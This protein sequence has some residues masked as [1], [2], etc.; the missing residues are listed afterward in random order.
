[1]NKKLL[2]AAIAGTL[3]APVAIADVAVSG[4]I[5]VALVGD[6]DG[7]NTEWNI[8][9]SGSRL[10]FKAN[11]DLG[12]G[13]SG[14]VN[15][16]FGV[17]AGNGSIG[18]GSRNRLTVVGVKG[19][20]GNL[21]MGS[22]WSTQWQMVGNFIDKSN[23][24]GGQ[25]YQGQYRM[26]NSVRFRTELGALDLGVDAQMPSGGDDIDR[27]TV[28]LGGD[29][30]AVKWGVAWQNNGDSDYTGIGLSATLGNIKL[31]G[32]WSDIDGGNSGSNIN[33]GGL[34]GMWF[35]YGK[36]KGTDGALV[37]NYS[38]KIG[39][40]GSRTSIKIEGKAQDNDNR[41]IVILRKDF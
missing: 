4:S 40:K 28:G 22:Q 31:S 32:G 7:T 26:A 10:R 35:S 19:N 14:Y 2:A 36:V 13:S 15:Y 1:M 34:A 20:W 33:I 5:R 8:G 39:G 23:A 9:N 25:G 21:S 12:N 37:G 41:G 11:E 17:D 6:S 38:H 18:G 29:L 30:G 24:F 27:A 3:V 16:E